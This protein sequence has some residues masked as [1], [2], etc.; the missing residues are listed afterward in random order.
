[1]SA[2]DKN[3]EQNTGGALDGLPIDLLENLNVV[4]ENLS[5]IENS[6]R[7]MQKRAQESNEASL[8]YYLEMAAQTA[9]QRLREAKTQKSWLAGK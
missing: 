2:N 6:L 8:N 7:Q 1:M 3:E 5:F 9:E 4:I